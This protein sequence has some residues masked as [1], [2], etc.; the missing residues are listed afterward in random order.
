MGFANYLPIRTYY[1]VLMILKLSCLELFAKFAF[2][3]EIKR[4]PKKSIRFFN[5]REVRAVWD[6]ENNCWWFSAT[7]IVRAINNEP[8][9]TK[10]GN[11]WRWLKR[12]LK[13]EGIQLVSAAHG[14]KFEAPD[15]KLRMA[16]VLNSENVALLAKHYPN[17]RANEFL[18]W[19]TYSDNTLDGQSRKKAYQLYE[20]GLLRTLEPGSL[21]CLQQI[22][23]Y[24]LEGYTILLDRYAQRISQKEDLLLQIACISPKHSKSLS[25]CR[26]PLSM[27]L[28]TNISR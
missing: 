15:G 13:Q 27:R 17:N 3:E 5:D 26:K 1:I 22:H 11:Y 20:S 4:Q 25:V 24:I 18:D 12:K 6:D 9:Y 14:F 8:D 16:D 7:D 23:A 19:F 28:W 21:K 2:M 10:A